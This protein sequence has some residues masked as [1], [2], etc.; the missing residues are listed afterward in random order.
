MAGTIGLIMGAPTI[1]TIG[2]EVGGLQISKW[3]LWEHTFVN[4]ISFKEVGLR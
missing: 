4:M 3:E 2:L 1:P